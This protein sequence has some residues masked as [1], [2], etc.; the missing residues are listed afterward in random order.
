M[1]RCPYRA[2]AAVAAATVLTTGAA[3]CSGAGSGPAGAGR[4]SPVTIGL[5]A[6][7]SGPS[8]ADG[9]AIVDGFQLYVDLHG[10]ALGGHRVKLVVADEGDGGQATADAARRL[11]ER[12]RVMALVG[13]VSADATLSLRAAVAQARLAF[14]GTGDRPTGLDD[15]SYLWH[16]SWLAREPGAAI[17]EHIRTTVNGP[18]YVMASDNQGG[19]DNVAGFTEAFTA[20]G[21]ELANDGGRP[22]WTPWPARS[23]NYTPFFNRVAASDAKALYTCYSGPDAVDFVRQYAR[24]QL[25][26]T[27]P[28]FGPGFLT[29]EGLLAAEGAAADG[30]QTA[31]SYT[32]DLDIATNRAFVTEFT[33][34]FDT[35][36]RPLDVAGYDAAAVLDRAIAAAGPDP[37]G[38]AVNAQIGKIGAVDSPRGAWRWSL[39]HTPVQTWYLRQVATDGRGRANVLVKSLTALGNS[40]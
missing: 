30:V 24:S 23:V 3:G 13:A 9:H 2:W 16:V 1:S 5:I 37:S 20:L 8:T 17:A 25:R 36:P 38:E 32:P 14:V 27:V 35:A 29:D 11:I 28:L 7:E 19:H 22:A 40:G 26:G 10:G 6:P 34:R 12:E 18:V 15:L 4:R 39:D 33:K 31:L 21:G